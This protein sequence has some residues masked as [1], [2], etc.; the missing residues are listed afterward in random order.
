M[1]AHVCGG[2]ILVG[3]TGEQEHRYCDRCRAYTYDLD[4]EMPGGT[5]RAANVEA[6]DRGAPSSPRS[7]EQRR[8]GL[9][10]L[11]RATEEAGGHAAEDDEAK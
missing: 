4:A 3:G 8:R 9:R 11:T 6:F 10:E 1:S 2:T 5:D 7:T